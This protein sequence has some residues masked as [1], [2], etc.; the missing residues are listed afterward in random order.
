MRFDLNFDRQA[1][2][3]ILKGISILDVS[4]LPVSNL[5]QA[6]EFVL[7]YG[8]DLSRP[9]D[10]ENLWALHATAVEFLREELLEGEEKVPDSLAERDQ[11]K[12]LRN[13]LLFASTEEK[14]SNTIQRWS[15]AILRVMHVFAHHNNSVL[16]LFMTDIQSQLLSTFNDHIHI[17]SDHEIYL[18]P[19]EQGIRLMKF[20][21][22]TFKSLRSS[23]IKLLAKPEIVALD[24][25]DRLG[26][27]FITFSV[28]DAFRVL[29]YL[30]EKG[31]ISLPHVAPEQSNNS[32]Y[33]P[34]LFFEAIDQFKDAE[35]VPGAEEIERTMKELLKA[36]PE[37]ADF[38]RKLNSFTSDDYRFIKFI[39]RR[40]FR[41][42][43]KI[44]TL[45]FFFPCEIQITDEATYNKN[46]SGPASH[47]EYKE[48]QRKAARRRVFG[49]NL[50]R[51]GESP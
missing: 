50:H 43:S 36:N 3:S 17:L 20:E 40:L 8:F 45:R 24:L 41:V 19:K 5:E 48:R 12:D 2:E 22:K 10:E 29:R 7:A 44:G 31:V 15:C 39:V 13:L 47:E 16:D 33:P 38:K 26:F 46:R 27:R 32:L 6:T 42:E 9:E 35:A 11:L 21:V 25:L 4:R 23:I 51:Q 37:G 28:F 49:L 30:V 34:S 18:G 1:I 14:S